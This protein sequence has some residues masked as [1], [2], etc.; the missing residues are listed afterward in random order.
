MGKVKKLLLKECLLVKNTTSE[1]RWLIV[2]VDSAA[3][4]YSQSKK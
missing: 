2:V 3:H 4:F 1:K